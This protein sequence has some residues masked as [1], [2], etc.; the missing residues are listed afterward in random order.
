MR[1]LVIL[2][3]LAGASGVRAQQRFP[4]PAMPLLQVVARNYG[5]SIVLRWA[6]ATAARWL[7]GNAAGY[8]I[9]RIPVDSPF[10]LR[11]AA[12]KTFPLV[13]PATKEQFASLAKQGNSY[14]AAAGSSL[15]AKNQVP[16]MNEPTLEN[17]YRHSQEGDL[18]LMTAS[19]MADWD[20]AAA[21]ALGWRFTDRSFEKG[22]RYLYRVFAAYGSKEA[23]ADTTSVLVSTGRLD[24]P[25][26]M[27][28][29]SARPGD[30]AITLFWEKPLPGFDFSGYRI[31]RSDDDGRTFKMTSKLPLLF[32]QQGA[33]SLP[34]G[35]VWF[36][37]SV[38][39]NSKVY[40]YRVFGLDAFGDLSPASPVIAA[41]AV[42]RTPPPPPREVS[43]KQLDERRVLITWKAPEPV[44]PDFGGYLVSTGHTVDGPFRPLFA[45][46]LPK[47]T[48][49]F[50]DTSAVAALPNFY[51][52]TAIDTFLNASHAPAAY[53]FYKDEIPP[54]LPVGLSGSMDSTGW[55]TLRWNKSKDPDLLGYSVERANDPHHEFTTVTTGFLADTVFYDSISLKTLSQKIYYRLRTFDRSRNGSKPSAV[56]ELEKPDQIP[57][58]PPVIKDF[59]IT[60]SSVTFSWLPSPSTDVQKMV[61]L[62]KEIGGNF[63]VWKELPATATS[64][65]D[66]EVQGKAWYEYTLV[67]EDRGGLRSEL[68]FPL[69]V[70]VYPGASAK[71]E[72]EN[73]TAHLNT[74]KTGIVLTW[75]AEAVAGKS[76]LLYRQEN[77]SGFEMYQYLSGDA[78]SWVDTNIKKGLTYSYALKTKLAGGIESGLQMSAP[79]EVK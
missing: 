33:D 75:Q 58:M 31:E 61:V 50:T 68:S 77:H 30:H 72:A 23:P 9:E 48:T 37:D 7:Q 79:L 42:D 35:L 40:Q 44:P 11:R 29:V 41:K 5:D 2:L 38:A 39:L 55:V 21:N 43:V 60:D 69:R 6:P 13:K 27:P 12:V 71:G 26:P 47:G 64:T 28:P 76:Y 70:R 34:V 54:E 25:S 62:K 15:Y 19:L 51:R 16:T 73:L 20:A 32:M 4:S 53:L 10:V 59:N 46:P 78:V 52:V 67:A 65:I 14:A 57:P 1:N 66:S 74:E 45:L 63:R 8:L 18:K 49:Q 3:L 36:T 56:L 24:A 22:K 17:L